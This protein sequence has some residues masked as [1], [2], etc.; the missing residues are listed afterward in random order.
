MTPDRGPYGT[1]ARRLLDS[2]LVG[3]L[4]IVA[5]RF[6]NDLRSVYL[7]ACTFVHVLLA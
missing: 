2:Q 1:M 4:R 5:T 6:L 3:K 7:G